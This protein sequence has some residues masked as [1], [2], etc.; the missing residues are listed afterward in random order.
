AS[1]SSSS[2]AANLGR[3]HS[4]PSLQQQQGVQSTSTSRISDVLEP[5]TPVR[6]RLGGVMTTMATT[7]TAKDGGNK[8]T[9]KSPRKSQLQQTRRAAAAAPSPAA[10]V[11]TSTTKTS[12]KGKE[13]AREEEPV[14][15]TTS[16]S[17]EENEVPSPESV[18]GPAV[19]EDDARDDAA[20]ER[21]GT[22]IHSPAARGSS[23]RVVGEE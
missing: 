23:R 12:N 22:A 2:A 20:A 5:R 19:V 10:A 11:E 8:A 4:R 13:P 7:T 1:A 17:Y 6:S 16:S 18:I 14:T 21:P 9:K 15:T 3:S